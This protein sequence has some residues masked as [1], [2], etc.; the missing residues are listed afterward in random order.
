[1]PCYIFKFAPIYLEYCQS[2]LQSTSIWLK[3]LEKKL[4]RKKF[5]VNSLRQK[6]YHIKHKWHHEFGINDNT[7]LTSRL[8]SG[9]RPGNP[10]QGGQAPGWQEGFMQVIGPASFSFKD[11]GGA[12]K[13]PIFTQLAS[14]LIKSISSIPKNTTFDT[15]ILSSSFSFVR[16]AQNTPP[17]FWNRKDWR[18]PVKNWSP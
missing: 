3:L 14:W 9:G 8:E 10:G 4:S 15:R 6:K 11:C 5:H 7:I 18:A 16:D 1:M 2:E 13:R 12:S 17:G